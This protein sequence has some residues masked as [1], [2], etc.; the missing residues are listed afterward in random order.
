M[1]K[2]THNV[3]LPKPESIE[4]TRLTKVTDSASE[5]RRHRR[6]IFV[7]GCAAMFIF[8]LLIGRLA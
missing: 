1:L 5:L 8:G 6:Q 4:F 3:F 7:F 2:R